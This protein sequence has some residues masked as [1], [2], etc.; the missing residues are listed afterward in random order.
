MISL[1]DCSLALRGAAPD[2]MT[3]LYGN[4]SKQEGFMA[5]RD[6]AARNRL[7]FT[8]IDFL[9]SLDRRVNPGLMKA[10]EFGEFDFFALHRLARSGADEFAAMLQASGVQE[11]ETMKP[12]AILAERPELLSVLLAQPEMQHVKV[13]AFQTTPVMCERVLTVGSVPFYTGILSLRR[14]AALIR[15]PVS[16]STGP[17]RPPHSRLRLLHPHRRFL[18]RRPAP[19]PMGWFASSLEAGHCNHPAVRNQPA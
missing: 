2:A 7:N 10:T 1:F 16:R 11:A 9:V 3:A 18:R 17:R 13:V 8:V 12:A 4:Q 19:L 14:P 6:Y 15:P 5:A